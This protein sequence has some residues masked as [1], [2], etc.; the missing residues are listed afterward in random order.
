MRHSVKRK[1]AF[2]LCKFCFTKFEHIDDRIKTINRQTKE[3]VTKYST[4][5][6]VFNATLYMKQI[7][8][9]H[10]LECKYKILNYKL[11][12]YIVFYMYTHIKNMIEIN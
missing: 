12:Y 9:I 11:K 2:G 7:L 5:K 4:D 3:T 10:F 6:I 8:Y 1:P